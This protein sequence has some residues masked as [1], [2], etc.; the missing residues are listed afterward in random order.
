MQR[1]LASVGAHVTAT[2]PQAEPAA[3]ALKSWLKN[4]L[5]GNAPE[6]A[7]DEA[8]TEHATE[9]ASDSILGSTA[10]PAVR[11]IVKQCF[12][13]DEDWVGAEVRCKPADWCNLL[14]SQVTSLTP[15]PVVL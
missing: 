12:L 15:T 7:P 8:S 11:G 13:A 5:G 3:G 4:L 14:Y 10:L 1:R 2:A 9:P 6:K